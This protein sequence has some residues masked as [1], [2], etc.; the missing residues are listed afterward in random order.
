MATLLLKLRGPLQSWGSESRYTSRQTHTAPTKSGV[1]GLLAAALGRRRTDPVEDL[2]ALRFGVRVDQPGRLTRD[3]QTAIDWR[4]GKPKP[5]SY[6]YYLS[7]AVFVAGVE[8]EKALI[9]GL[10]EA[11]HTPGFPLYLGRRSCPANPDLM[12]GLLEEDLE[13]ALRSVEWQ[14]SERRRRECP[15]EV[16]LPLLLD[17]PPGT[18]G[19]AQRDVPVSF[20]PEHRKYEWRNVLT[21]DPVH[22]NNDKGKD[23]VDPFFEVVE[24]A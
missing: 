17:A 16:N 21:A 6:R 11:V 5:L 18:A 23:R 10:S 14:A 7:D 20:D 12:L 4:T 1:L 2:A 3:F 9:E 13:T 15:R 8:G 22:F 19:D 24:S